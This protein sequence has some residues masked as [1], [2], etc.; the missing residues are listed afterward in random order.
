MCS[1]LRKMWCKS[2]MEPKEPFEPRAAVL[3]TLRGADPFLKDC[4][5]GLLRQEYADYTVFFVFDSDSDPALPVVE[6]L[7]ARETPRSPGCK[8]EIVVVDEHLETC[9]LKCN[10]LVHV[11]ETLDDSFQVVAIL[12]ADTQPFPSWLRQLVEPLS[13]PR[14]AVTSGLRWYVPE[15]TNWG[16]LVRML[17]NVAAVNQMV[18][19]QIPWGGSFAL[20]RE[21]FITGGLLERWKQTFTDDVSSYS[22]VRKM[23]AR[24]MVTPSLLMVNREFC[25]TSSFYAWVKRQLLIAKLYHPNWGLIV[26]QA[27]FLSA[28]LVLA[29]ILAIYGIY[30]R[31]W[32]IVGW[33]VGA[34]VLYITGVF[35]AFVLMDGDVRRYLRQNDETISRQTVWGLCKTSVAIALTQVVYSVAI[36]GIFRMKKV[37]WRGITYFITKPDRIQMKKFIP[38]SEI[39]KEGKGLESL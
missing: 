35:G 31:N 23:G 16:S 8:W 21:V 1:F 28:P 32:Q 2:W 20:R 5:Q 19:S 13:D 18:F 9:S 7:L 14:Y 24:V 10:S 27:F 26:G 34:L 33:N 38:Y 3:L 25:R 37:E 30:V 11:I 6:E 39:Q 36:C 12:D 15:F 4:V 22:I 29:V 17:W